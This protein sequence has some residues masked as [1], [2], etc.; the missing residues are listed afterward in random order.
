MV[1]N[2]L[3]IK[4]YAFSEEIGANAKKNPFG[5]RKVICGVRTWRRSHHWPASGDVWVRACNVWLPQCPGCFMNVVVHIGKQR[6]SKPRNCEFSPLPEQNDDLQFCLPREKCEW[7]GRR[8]RAPLNFVKESF[9]DEETCGDRYRIKH[10]GRWL[11]QRVAILTDQPLCRDELDVQLSSL[12]CQCFSHSLQQRW[13][14]RL[15]LARWAHDVTIDKHAV[16]ARPSCCGFWNLVNAHAWKFPQAYGAFLV[17]EC[18]A[19][20]TGIECTKQ[21]TYWKGVCCS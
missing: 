17:T 11:D 21:G 2:A 4:S 6:L 8:E 14:L 19:A 5:R 9:T 10:S 20:N 18:D 13:P 15:G 16:G 12:L 7:W 3:Q 1:F